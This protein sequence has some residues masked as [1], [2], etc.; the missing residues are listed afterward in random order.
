M[1]TRTLRT[2]TIAL[3]ALSMTACAHTASTADRAPAAVKYRELYEM[4]GYD[5]IVKPGDVPRALATG[6]NE[7]IDRSLPPRDPSPSLGYHFALKPEQSQK[8]VAGWQ[9]V[10]NVITPPAMA[11]LL[12][13]T[14]YEELIAKK[15]DLLELWKI[16][17]S[18]YSPSQQ[19][20][21]DGPPAVNSD[22]EYFDISD[23]EFGYCWGYASLNRF[24]AQVAFYDPAPPLD[25]PRYIP[26]GL[27]KNEAWF[28]YYQKKIDRIL[29]GHAE[30]IPGFTDFRSFASIPEIEFYLKLKA[31]KLWSTNAVSWGSLSTF[32]TSTRPMNAQEIG[33]LINNLV[34]RLKRGELPKILFTAKNSK[35]IMGGSADV[36]VVLVTGIERT[37]GK[38]IGNWRIQLWDINYYAED[39][40]A[41]PK[42]LEIRATANGRE[43]HYEPWYEKLATDQ[44][45]AES[46]QLGQVRLAAENS[47]E[48]KT[49]I[50]SLAVFCANEKTRHYCRK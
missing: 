44:L 32:F 13:S 40:L 49:M 24:F 9:F 2:L 26:H 25:A 23:R 35:K 41:E 18:R 29:T 45:T 42:Y 7:V 21:E 43:I 22:Y 12:P 37:P 48:M 30:V 14:T 16:H 3:F 5:I 27:H 34:R 17:R 20:I 46:T 8:S 19:R 11:D 6:A 38:P 31:M 36:H 28:R 47:A 10:K 50:R 15:P 1:K 39:Y 33:D 4:L